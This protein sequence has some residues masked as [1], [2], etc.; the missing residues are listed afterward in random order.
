MNLPEQLL[1]NAGH[2]RQKIRLLNRSLVL[3]IFFLLAMS[4]RLFAQ[5]DK[6][7]SGTV[8]DE[9]DRTLPGVNITLKGTSTGTTTD[10]N[11][12]Y[13]LKVKTGQGIL[14]FSFIGYASIEESINNRTTINI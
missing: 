1:S 12:H 3:S 5:A 14:I 2:G 7:V 4:C 10:A 9:H 11:G 13:S 6:T 8:K